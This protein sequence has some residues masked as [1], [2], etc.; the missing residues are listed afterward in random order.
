V[1][2]K[3]KK[4]PTPGSCRASLKFRELFDSVVGRGGFYG[5]VIN[6]LVQPGA[7]GIKKRPAV[8]FGGALKAGYGEIRIR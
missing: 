1:F 4:I 5:F 6:P 3:L 8:R 2:V 7:E